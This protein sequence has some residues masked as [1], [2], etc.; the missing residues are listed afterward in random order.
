[1]ATQ[2]SMPASGATN[3]STTAKDQ[4]VGFMQRMTN[5]KVLVTGIVVVS[6]GLTGLSFV[7]GLFEMDRDALN[8]GAVT[9]SMIPT[10]V[11]ADETIVTIN[12]QA[13]SRKEIQDLLAPYASERLINALADPGMASPDLG[14]NMAAT[15]SSV[16]SAKVIEDA[17]V[18]AGAGVSEVEVQA[19]LDQ[20]I[21][22]HFTDKAAYEKA[23]VAFDITEAGMLQQLRFPME[24]ERLTDKRHP[25]SDAQVEAQIQPVYDAKY[26][27]GKMVYHMQFP[28]LGEADAAMAKLIA[29]EPFDQVAKELSKDPVT[30]PKGGLIGPWQPGAMDAAFDNAVEGTKAG[31]LGGPFQ[32]SHGW[33]I[34][35]VEAV[36]PLDQ[37][38][39]EIKKQARAG[40]QASNWV[41]LAD[42]LEEAAGLVIDPRYGLWK[43][44]AFGGL[45]RTPIHLQSDQDRLNGQS[46]GSLD[47]SVPQAELKPAATDDPEGKKN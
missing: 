39:D 1:M 23:L 7:P 12:G 4:P 44:M 3:G 21:D 6:M 42:E 36:P 24:A 29:G 28:T 13:Y 9:E 46:E 10:P 20:F 14:A 40:I 32:A 33:H 37:V 35:R 19:Q 16:I 31:A 15:L 27:S 30:A 26:K 25:I 8:P 5:L 38:R 34:I 18:K 11:G 47:S 2:S 41:S 17:V 43:G 45:S 22:D